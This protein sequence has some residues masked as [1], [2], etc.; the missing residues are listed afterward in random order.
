ML[1]QPTILGIA[2]GSRAL[3]DVSRH[4]DMQTRVIGPGKASRRGLRDFSITHKLGLMVWSLVAVG[5]SLLLVVSVSMNIATGVRAYVGG[6]G[7]Y[8]KG[9]KDA[10]YYLTRYARFRDDADF[11]K[12]QNAI[13]V[14]LGDH[15]ARVEMQKPSFD[16]EVAAQGF[17][18]GGND[19]QD[20][21]Y[22]I[23]LFRWFHAGS[24]FA[25]AI[26]L[27][28]QADVLVAELQGQG[29]ALHAE[30]SSSAAS[31]ARIAEILDRVEQI[32]VEITPIERDFSITLGAAARWIKSLLLTTLYA[33]AALLLGGSVW[34][35]GLIA[36]ELRLGIVGLRNAAQRVSRGD[37]TVPVEVR[38]RDELGDLA[39]TFNQMIEHRRTVEDAL[40]TATDFQQKVMQSANDAIYALDLDGNF[41]LANPR[42]SEITGY[43]NPSLLGSHYER[44]F[45]AQDVG[46]V[47]EQFNF[48]ARG[49]GTVSNFETLLRRRDGSATLIKFN[50]APLIRDGRVAGVVGTTEDIAD[51]RKDELELLERGR[52][53][54]RLNRIHKMHSSVSA[55][56]VRAQDR[57]TLLQETCRIAVEAGGFLTAFVAALDSGSLDGRAIAWAGVDQGYAEKIRAT[58]RVDSEFASRP[59]NVAL[60]DGVRV[61]CNDL[62]KD[63]TVAPIREDALARGFRSGAAFPILLDGHAN[64]VLVLFAAEVGFFNL[65]EVKLLEELIGDVS[66]A[67]GA[68]VK[69]SRLQFLAN[70]D[71][72]TGL[73]NREL[74]Q[75]RLGQQLLM[76][77]RDRTELALTVLEIERFDVLSHSL[78]QGATDH[79]VAEMAHRLRASLG[80]QVDLA[81]VT[82]KAFAA[83]FACKTD[84]AVAVIDW[85]DRSLLSVF[86]VPFLID[87]VELRFSGRV[88]VALFPADNQDAGALLHNAESA[89]ERAHESSD[90]VFFYSP[91]LNQRLAR[92]LEMETKLRRAIEREEFVV[93]YQP[94]LEINSNVVVGAEALLRWNDPAAGL[95]A[96]AEFIPFLEE[97]GLILEV[98]RWL[99]GKV[100][101]DLNSF[102]ARGIDA[103][104][105]AVNISPLHLQHRDFLADVQM[106]ILRGK[107]FGNRMDLELTES[108]VMQDI[109]VSIEKLQVVRSVGL[110]IA[111]DDFGTGYS[112]LAYLS[113]LPATALKIDQNFIMR[114]QSDGHV[115]NLVSTIISLAHSLKLKVI[116]EGVETTEQLQTLRRLNCDQYQGFVYSAGVPL[117]ALVAILRG[118]A[119]LSGRGI[120]K[121]QTAAK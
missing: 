113:R 88:G 72:L 100:A 85:I 24:Y 81:R 93:H 6:E 74:F 79:L 18:A 41:T 22:L 20:V 106:A 35:S 108:M 59:G 112:S 63:E 9:Q 65:E 53:L 114:M 87:G 66:L 57:E 21:P 102:T 90:K 67:L 45:D 3:S 76:A 27:W 17:I 86:N 94:K 104:R 49:K 29:D 84:T 13:T 71:P 80:E 97:T 110:D 54:V 58:V 61:V 26:D 12:F 39:A 19:P 36:R 40:R 16:R 83:V 96:P 5:F 75:D 14:P 43:D 115:M 121:V 107:K 101:D 69:E 120:A 92:R 119:A 8:S 103:P 82:H 2:E 98:S 70:F 30:I 95:I 78:G 117:E 64:A 48:V 68:I 37:L 33:V 34:L 47:R 4:D 10:I 99:L 28:A 77:E 23:G 46:A 32:N 56:I 105:I 55:M 89:L 7:L 51:R 111:I 44:L 25:R 91:E 118:Q 109:E 11:H 31:E 60:R 42:T 1:G 50:L 38:S 15:Q 73:A 116:A 52:E 62:A